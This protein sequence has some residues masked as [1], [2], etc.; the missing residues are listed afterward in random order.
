M[1]ITNHLSVPLLIVPDPYRTW[2]LIVGTDG[3]LLQPERPIGE[4]Y[5]E[6]MRKADLSN[7]INAEPLTRASFDRYLEELRD[8]KAWRW[9]REYEGD[10]DLPD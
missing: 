7:R 2:S 4:V 1:I 10:W 8:D 5:L 9:K 6:S 3:K